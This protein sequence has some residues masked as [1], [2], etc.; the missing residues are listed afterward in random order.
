MEI[1]KLKIVWKFIT[2]GTGGVV[3][4]ILD[5]ANNCVNKLDNGN[6]E[7]IQKVVRSL[8]SILEFATK[9]DW[10]CPEKWRSDYI[11]TVSVLADVAHA[12]EDLKLT[13]EELVKIAD[14]WRIA[15]SA[16]M[17]D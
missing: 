7:T 6:K 15:Y 12:A 4:Y 5:V 11:V 1:S 14:S 9:Y 16:W 2:G 17:A 10:L 13:E 3:S 8:K